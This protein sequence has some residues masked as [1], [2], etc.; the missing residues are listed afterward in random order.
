MFRRR[1]I[2]QLYPSFLAVTLVALVVATAYSSYALHSFYLTQVED[3]LRL[4]AEVTTPQIA[5]TLK[6]GTPGAVDV[7]CKKLGKA[8]GGARC[9]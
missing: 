4:T 2:W 3:E 5:E 6:A 9:V 8:G 1:L 7:L